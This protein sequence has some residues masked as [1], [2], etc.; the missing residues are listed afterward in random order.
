MI[1]KKIFYENLK[2]TFITPC[3]CAGADQN[4]PEVRAS[5]IR[6]Q[7]RWWFRVLGGTKE[8]EADVF[9]GVGESTKSS[10]IIIRIENQQDHGL[11]E[12]K[13]WTREAL[14]T[15][16]SFM[17]TILQRSEINETNLKKLKNALD[18]FLHLGAIGSH[19][20]RGYGCFTAEN[21][22][23]EIASLNSIEFP[24][25]FFLKKISVE[26]FN[27]GNECR[28]YLHD[29]LKSFRERYDDLKHEK[30]SALGYVKNGRES[31]ALK[32]RPVE[33]DGKFLP[34]IYYSDAACS[35]KSILDR[36]KNTF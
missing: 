2:L 18:A 35:Q 8:Q 1:P 17:L 7:L 12:T 5:S 26:N 23:G 30:R 22:T 20:T 29:R 10:K 15:G 28:K 25:D 11:K 13:V 9:G 6:G 36:I 19:A 4:K 21:L 24:L 3:V 14:P 34:Y 27:S 32:L 31:S 33:V 16:Y